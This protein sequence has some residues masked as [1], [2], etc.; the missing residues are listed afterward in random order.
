[1]PCTRVLYSGSLHGHTADFR[2]AVD[3]AQ[4]RT[5]QLCDLLR[6]LL[7]VG[8]DARLRQR[9]ELSPSDCMPA[10]SRSSSVTSD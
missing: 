1:M 10:L 3:E 5:L 7:A 2:T 9:N 4:Q 8:V 6:Q